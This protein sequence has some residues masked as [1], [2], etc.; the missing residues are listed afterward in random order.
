MKYTS[1]NFSLS[2]INM[3]F[4]KCNFINWHAIKRD[5]CCNVKDR[6][7]YWSGYRPPPAGSPGKLTSG[8]GYT[9]Y[10]GSLFDGIVKPSIYFSCPVH[11]C[12][13]REVIEWNGVRMKTSRAKDES[14]SEFLRSKDSW[15]RPTAIRNG[16]DGAL[17]V[18][19]MYRLVIEHPEWID[20]QLTKEMI[21][22]GR[23]RAGH[24]K[25]RIYRVWPEGRKLHPV[26]KLSGMNAEQLAEAIDSP[27]AWQ[28]DMPRTFV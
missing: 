2:Q 6:L 18:A 20:K 19:D 15:F 23:L 17:Y 25:G 21:E 4:K 7:I 3:I 28:R 1:K 11:N 12:I 16:P 24:D 27:N 8:C 9:F 10:R 14:N 5:S 22:D 13:H 26:R